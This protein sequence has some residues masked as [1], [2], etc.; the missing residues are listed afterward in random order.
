MLQLWIGIKSVLFFVAAACFGL[1]IFYGVDTI[2]IKTVNYE[3]RF[4]ETY[5][6]SWW[7]YDK[8]QAYMGIL[9]CD[10]FMLLFIILWMLCSRRKM[11]QQSPQYPANHH[12][13]HYPADESYETKRTAV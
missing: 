5:L 10:V 11:G 1:S 7:K 6:H 13:L 3:G 4:S 2:G 8:G 12:H 9:G